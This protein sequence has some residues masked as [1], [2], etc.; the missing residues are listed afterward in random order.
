MPVSFETRV[1]KEGINYLVEADEH[2]SSYLNRK[3][4]IPV[5]G[6]IRNHKLIGTLVPRKNSRY[7]LFLNQEIRKS[8]GIKAGDLVQIL[9]EYDHESRELP[10]PLDLEDALSQNTSAKSGFYKF[11]ASHKRELI[12]WIND[13]RKVETREKRITKALVHCVEHYNNKRI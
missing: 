10:V 7:V 6:I 4:F 3:G 11:T 8:A 13:A 1:Y 2:V 12:V 5:R 9:L